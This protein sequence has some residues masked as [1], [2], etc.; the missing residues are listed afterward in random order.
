MKRILILGDINSAH[1]Q[2]WLAVLKQHKHTLAV[3]SLSIPENDWYLQEEIELLSENAFENKQFH[4]KQ[5]QKIAYLKRRKDL[6]KA[7]AKW[8]PDVL[9]AHYA[10]SYGFLGALS[11]FH[12]FH[13]SVWGSD[14]LLFP[15]NTVNKRI[16]KYNFKKSDKIIVSSKTLETATQEYTNK[17]I[18]I[19]PFGIKT[20]LFT[21]KERKE[22]KE[23]IVIGTV[24]SLEEVYGIDTLICAF[25]LVR[26]KMPDK[27]LVLKIVGEGTK[28]DTLKQ[29]TIDTREENNVQFFPRQ[30]QQELVPF[31]QSFDIA[32]FLSRSES[33]GVSILEASACQLPVVV[34]AVGGLME[35]VDDKKTGFFVPPEDIDAAA[36]R[37]IELIED[38][39]LRHKMGIAGREKVIKE[40]AIENTVNDILNIYKEEEQCE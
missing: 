28:E 36:N 14:V 9:H 26:T 27:N 30:S 22:D 20:T 32:V 12:P 35:V 2:K 39:E 29:L 1:T 7:I 5:H 31:Y 25:H 3:F 13:L 24:K 15:S 4:A 17:Q 23:E 16:L 34:S 40:Y 33:F 38:K 10:S 19:I 21:P 18:K 11:G 37:I 8:K 6:K